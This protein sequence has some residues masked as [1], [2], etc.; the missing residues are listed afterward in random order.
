[1]GCQTI[2]DRR[3]DIQD[4]ARHSSEKLHDQAKEKIRWW[5]PSN[6][7]VQVRKILETTPAA[8]SSLSR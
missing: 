6:L 3:P 8:A 1:M 7:R 4:G 2:E 5:V